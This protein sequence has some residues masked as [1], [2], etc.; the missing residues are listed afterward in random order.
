MAAGNKDGKIGRIFREALAPYC[1]Q[2]ERTTDLFL[3]LVV[4]ALDRLVILWKGPHFELDRVAREGRNVD[5]EARG[6][7]VDHGQKHLHGMVAGGEELAVGHLEIAFLRRNEQ[8]FP[9]TAPVRLGVVCPIKVRLGRRILRERVRGG[10]PCIVF[11]PVSL[12]RA[13][14]RVRHGGAGSKSLAAWVSEI[15]CS[16][17][18]LQHTSIL[19]E[20]AFQCW[21][22]GVAGICSMFGGPVFY[23]SGGVNRVGPLTAVTST[24]GAGGPLP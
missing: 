18:L 7:Q 13:I 10:E 5:I 9:F 8:Y 6:I 14:R 11:G 2:V 19:L 22:C 12:G 16:R 21:T 4:Y 24:R 1:L 20:G 3:I 17:F 23:V 15:Y